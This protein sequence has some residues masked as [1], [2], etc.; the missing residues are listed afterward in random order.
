M[1]GLLAL[2]LLALVIGL[3]LRFEPLVYLF[4]ALVGIYLSNRLWL[5]RSLRAVRGGRVIGRGRDRGDSDTS[6]FLGDRVEVAL[7]LRN[8]GLLPVAWTVVEEGLPPG[9][10]AVGEARWA[11]SLAPKERRTLHYQLVCTRRGYYRSA[12]W[13]PAAAPPGRPSAVASRSRRWTT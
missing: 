5:H 1:T 3:A 2:G 9:L 12:R 13:S 7:P 6:A 11:L 10:R 8:E 4:Y